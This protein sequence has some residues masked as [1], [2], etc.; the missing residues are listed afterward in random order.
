MADR[1]RLKESNFRKLRTSSAVWDDLISRAKDGVEYASEGGEVRGYSY[2][3]QYSRTN[4]AAVTVVGKGHARNHN[5][6]HNTLLKMLDRIS[7]DM[8]KGRG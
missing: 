2:S 5:R 4:R 8:K 6:K 3:P 1:F 7:D